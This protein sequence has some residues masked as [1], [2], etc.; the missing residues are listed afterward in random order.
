MISCDEL[1]GEAQGDARRKGSFSMTGIRRESSLK[2][3]FD[4]SSA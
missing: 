1:R 2:R 4:G 3:G